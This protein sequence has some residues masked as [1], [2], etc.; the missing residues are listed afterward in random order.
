VNM[1][2]KIVTITYEDL[3]K[4]SPFSFD[5]FEFLIGKTH[6]LFRVQ[7]LMEWEDVLGLDRNFGSYGEFVEANLFPNC[8]YA[9]F[10][11]CTSTRPIQV[12]NKN[13]NH[14]MVEFTCDYIGNPEEDD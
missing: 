8:K 3:K 14:V 11:D 6:G 10:I 1:T 4:L 5:E 9:D 12:I 7:I 2:N 13:G